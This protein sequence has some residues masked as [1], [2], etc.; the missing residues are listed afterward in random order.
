MNNPKQIMANNIKKYLNKHRKT[1]TDLARDLNIPETTVSNWVKAYTYPR[2]DKIQLMA[3]YFGVNRADLTE[4]KPENVTYVSDNFV[5]VPILGEIAC[6]EPLYVAENFVGYKTESS[7]NL[8]SG[9]IFYLEAK[10]KSME[11][12]IPDGSSVLVRAQSEV[13]NGEIA[14]VL[15]NGDTEATLKRIKKQDGLIILMPDNPTFEPIVASKKYPVRIIGK[16]IRF[17]VDL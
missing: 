3:D 8:P 6:G 5:K 14:A 7:D 11:P 4:D 1:Q 2:V 9:D 17:T 12:T 16:A 15:V 13:E 10:G